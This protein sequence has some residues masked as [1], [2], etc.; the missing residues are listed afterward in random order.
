VAV[1]ELLI[2]FGTSGLF[3]VVGEATL[4]SRSSEATKVVIVLLS[5]TERGES[6]AEEL[7]FSS[8]DIFHFGDCSSAILL[9]CVSINDTFHPHEAPGDQGDPREEDI[10]PGLEPVLLSW[11]NDLETEFA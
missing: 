10:E 8:S 7:T 6:V 4:V 3:L 1:A 2:L 11:Y 5:D 9:L